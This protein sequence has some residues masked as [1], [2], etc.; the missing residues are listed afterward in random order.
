MYSF[1]GGLH[2]GC[3]HDRADVH[4]PSSFIHRHLRRRHLTEMK[5]DG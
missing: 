3:V 2:I 4:F 5:Y 1:G